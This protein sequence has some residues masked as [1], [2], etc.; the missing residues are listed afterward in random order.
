[1]KNGANCPRCGHFI[2]DVEFQEAEFKRRLR[3]KYEQA[4]PSVVINKKT[5]KCFF[6]I[7]GVSLI[8]C[9]CS[10]GIFSSC[11]YDFVH[12]LGSQAHAV[13]WVA[14]TII[15]LMFFLLSGFF[16]IVWN[17]VAAGKYKK[18]L[19]ER[20]EEIYETRKRILTMLGR[21]DLLDELNIEFGRK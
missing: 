1:M 12:N 3:V 13:L 16:P 11:Y 15:L 6:V 10:Y 8:A 7:S 4:N 20:D 14:I 18:Y 2:S 19:K 17:R 21:S 5:E 9:A